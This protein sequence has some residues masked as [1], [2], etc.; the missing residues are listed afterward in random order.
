MMHATRIGILGGTF[1]PVHHGHVDAALAAKETLKL[2]EVLFVP[3]RLTPHKPPAR[4]VSGYHRFAMLALATIGYPTF[5]VSDLE[6]RSSKP[7]YTSLT[8]RQ[9]SLSGYDP[10]QLFFIA[11]TDTFAQIAQWHDYPD[12][13][14]QSHFVV[15]S[16]PGFPVSKLFNDMPT[17]ADRMQP[18]AAFTKNNAGQRETTAIWLV[19]VATRNVS[20]STI[21]NR[22]ANGQSVNE[23]VPSAITTYITSQRL[24]AE[25]DIVSRSH[26]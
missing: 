10:T 15:V 26:E 8:L 18:A 21:R 24:Y 2:N 4:H 16:R 20:S 14:K 1:D 22:L 3:A 23:M 17:L 25:P 6:L 5:R 13:L 19:D 11:G 9:L 7:S 12:V